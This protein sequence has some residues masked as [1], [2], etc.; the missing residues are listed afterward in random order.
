MLE[1]TENA[2]KELDAFFDGK[3]RTSIRVYLASGGC[4]GPR[5]ALALDTP[6]ETDTVFDEKGFSFVINS[7]LCSA[8]KA[9]KV[10][11][12]YMGFS[13]ESEIPLAVAGGGCSCCGGC[14][15]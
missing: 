11:F 6:T 3:E 7:D 10:D 2:C 5:L 13:V 9:I 4:S 15:A 12:S 14:P 8:A 1:I